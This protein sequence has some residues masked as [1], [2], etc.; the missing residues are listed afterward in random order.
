V[1]FDFLSL[2]SDLFAINFHFF[3]SSKIQKGLYC[4]FRIL[5]DPNLSLVASKNK[6]NKLLL[7]IEK[8]LAIGAFQIFYL[9]QPIDLEN[10][11][12]RRPP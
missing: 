2:T 5:K 8:G 6:I 7:Y 12:P 11:K 9:P 1:L 4:A 10:L 3:G